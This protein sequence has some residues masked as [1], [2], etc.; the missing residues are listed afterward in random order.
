[1]SLGVEEHER[2]RCVNLLSVPS[3]EMATHE[4]EFLATVQTEEA[5]DED[6]QQLVAAVEEQD[7]PKKRKGN[8]LTRT[9]T[10]GSN[11]KEARALLRSQ[12]PNGFYVCFSG[13]RKIR[14]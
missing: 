8:A 13:K 6:E 5:N 11:P 2:S 9:E 12:L 14:T 3:Q 1:M 10:L 7:H 4:P